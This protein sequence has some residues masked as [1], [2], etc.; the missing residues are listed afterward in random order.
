MSELYL[1]RALR[2]ANYRDYGVEAQTRL[3]AV[4]LRIAKHRGKT[5]TIQYF[6][7]WGTVRAREL[8]SRVTGC[9]PPS[10]GGYSTS[11]S[12]LRHG[13]RI[14]VHATL[15]AAMLF[16]VETQSAALPGG[17]RLP[18]ERFVDAYELYLDQVRIDVNLHEPVRLEKTQHKRKRRNTAKQSHLT[19][20]DAALVARDLA[21]RVAYLDYCPH[22]QSHYL[23][24]SEQIIGQLLEEQTSLTT[25]DVADLTSCPLCRLRRIWLCER[26]NSPLRSGGSCICGHHPGHH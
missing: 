15:F 24:P 2:V 6:T 23:R 1:T 16:A 14:H 26:C 12:L 25:A 17:D 7:G 3:D 10:G 22:C 20:D 19:I 21:A 8:Y 4:A 13:A 11:C 5:G 18:G 9:R